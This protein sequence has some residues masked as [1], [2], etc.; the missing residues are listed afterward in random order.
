MISKKEKKEALENVRI[1]TYVVIFLAGILQCILP[2]N[3]LCDKNGFHC[4]PCGMRHAIDY[5]LELEFSQAYHSNPLI[6]VILLL[7]CVMVVDTLVILINRIRE[8]TR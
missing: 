4:P 1:I 5:V 3:Y 2:F 8:K 7:A 6:V